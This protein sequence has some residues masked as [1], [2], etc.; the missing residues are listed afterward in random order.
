MKMMRVIGKEKQE[1]DVP[2]DQVE[3]M[4]C[5][6]WIKATDEPAAKVPAKGLEK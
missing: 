2:A 1:R 6:G 4:L 3:D 5:T